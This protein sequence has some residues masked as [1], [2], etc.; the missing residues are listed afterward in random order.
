M[1]FVPAPDPS[2]RT[3]PEAPRFEAAFH[4]HA[5]SVWRFVR[6]LGVRE[7]DVEDVCQ[8]VFLVVHRRLPS[9]EGASS[10]RTW[11]FGIASRVASEYRRRPHHRREEIAPEA[12][13][14]TSIDPTQEA[15]LERRRAL[16]RLDR[17]L[18]TL[19]HDKRAVFVLFEIEEL[20]MAEVAA[21]AG[22]PLQTAYAR[23]YAARR[24]LQSELA[25][26]EG[27]RK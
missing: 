2:S 14:E 4:E 1:L 26:A 6:R 27:A 11:I 12:L 20:P 25:P 15:D 23:L 8:E 5:P 22:C 3:A 13:P 16:A 19:D 21:A 18:E 24:I 10:L 17:A 9:F 7:A